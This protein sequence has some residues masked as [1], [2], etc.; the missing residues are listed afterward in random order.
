[1]TRFTAILFV[2]TKV[3]SSLPHADIHETLALLCL[4]TDTKY[5]SFRTLHLKELRT[6]PTLDIAY[7]FLLVI[8]VHF[9]LLQRNC[10]YKIWSDWLSVGGWPSASRTMI[11]LLL[12]RPFTQSGGLDQIY[13]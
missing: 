8:D 5:F 13:I 11:W 4:V 12:C 3:T 2:Q 9:Y 6:P 10:S 7:N 1:M